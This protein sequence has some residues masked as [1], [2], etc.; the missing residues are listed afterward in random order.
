ML[1]YKRNLKIQINN[2]KKSNALVYPVLIFVIAQLSWFILLSLWIYW[3]IT[4]HLL[5]N[6][7]GD[8]LVPQ[9]IS[10]GI[11]I[12]ALISGIVLL[13][14]LSLIL[15]LFFI[16]LHRQMNVSR[17]YDNFIAINGLG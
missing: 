15:T 11:N 8:D 4:N 12:A 1:Y 9:I 6:K 5:L 13:I 10:G 14:V 3:Y 17:L 7:I 16:Y 2:M